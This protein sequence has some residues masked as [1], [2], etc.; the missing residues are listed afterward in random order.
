MIRVKWNMEEAVAL[1]DL[2]IKSGFSLN[3]GKNELEGLS[4]VL[5]KRAEIKGIVVDDKFRN[6]SGLLM[7]IRCIHYVTTG[8]KEGLSNASKIFYEAYELFESNPS[9]FKMIVDD[10]YNK[11]R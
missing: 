8:G 5:N 9:E 1:C 4:A 10:F 7:Q 3:I 6:I 2:Y 11:Y